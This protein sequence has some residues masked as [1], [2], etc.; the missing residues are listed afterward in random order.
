[1][2]QSHLTAVVVLTCTLLLVL[3]WNWETSDCLGCYLSNCRHAVMKC[4][5]FVCFFPNICFMH[6]ESFLVH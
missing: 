1:M 3:F 5:Y 6:A 2:V 4:A